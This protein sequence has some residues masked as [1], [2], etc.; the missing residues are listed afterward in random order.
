MIHQI[1]LTQ[2]ALTAI[3][4]K[5]YLKPGT[6]EAF[7][8]FSGRIY[9]VNRFF[10]AVFKLPA[11][12]IPD[13]LPDTDLLLDQEGVISR[14]GIWN[15]AEDGFIRLG[16]EFRHQTGVRVLFVNA[17]EWTVWQLGLIL[18]GAHS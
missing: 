8:E 12:M 7:D 5:K 17:R 14:V 10:D 16:F 4:E 1:E 9:P 2:D 13:L 3:T 6:L 18:K 15:E 11:E